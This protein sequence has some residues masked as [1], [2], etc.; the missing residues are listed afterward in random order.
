MPVRRHDK[1]RDFSAA[2]LIQIMHDI[3]KAFKVLSKGTLILPV[4]VSGDLYTI[5]YRYN[6]AIFSRSGGNQNRLTG[7]KFSLQRS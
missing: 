7:F 1:L 6:I 5:L 3:D 2:K 4:T